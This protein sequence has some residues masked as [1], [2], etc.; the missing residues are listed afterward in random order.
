MDAAADEI[1]REL[2]HL[3]EDSYGRPSSNLQV[4]IHH[5]FVAVVMEFELTEAERALVDSGNGD[6]VRTTREEFADAITA[7]YEAIVE[8]ATGRRVEGFASRVA[9]GV[10]PPW[11]ADVFRLG[12]VAEAQ[13]ALSE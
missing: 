3:H 9:L 1:A 2:V 10:D 6:A 11:S 4:A 8:R 5:D 7:V 12:P 13:E